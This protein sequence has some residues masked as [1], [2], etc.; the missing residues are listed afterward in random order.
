MSF[1]IEKLTEA[2]YL[3]L[4][5]AVDRAVKRDKE[6]LAKKKRKVKKKK[7]RKQSLFNFNLTNI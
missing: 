1:D 3:K 6:K 4:K 2:E 7:A 5:K